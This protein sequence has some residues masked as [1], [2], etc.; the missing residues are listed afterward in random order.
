MEGSRSGTTLTA[1]PD[2]RGADH[3]LLGGDS[4]ADC[5]DLVT[6]FFNLLPIDVKREK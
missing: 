2:D 6:F 3:R 1:P 4:A 5:S